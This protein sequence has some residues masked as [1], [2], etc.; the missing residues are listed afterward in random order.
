MFEITGDDVARL[1]D[2]D[3]RSLVGLLCA[4]EA[5]RL[6]FPASFITWGGHQD[7]ADGGLDV[8]VALPAVA[9]IDG[10]V[11]RSATGFQVKS[12]AMPRH[13]ILE[14]MRPNGTLRPAI[15]DL[16]DR[17]GA[18]VIV[19]SEDSTS[20]APLRNRQAAM[21]EGVRDLPNSDALF[22]DFYDRG[23]LATWVRDHPGLIPWVREKIG[24]PLKGWRS[25]GPWAYDPEGVRSEYLIDE[26][27]RLR[28]DTE[29]SDAGLKPLEGIDCI[30]DRLRDPRRIVR[31]VGLSG[32]GKTRLV[33]A[34]FDDRIGKSSLDPSLAFYTDMSEE[35]DPLPGGLASE[36]ISA[37]T[38][39]ILVIDNCSPD[40]HRRLSELCRLPESRVSVITVEYDI[41]EDQPE[42]T[43]VFKLEP[44]SNDLIEKIIKHRFRELSPVDVRTV[45][46]F[47]GGNARI[48]IALAATVGNKETIAG[49]TD[50]ELFRRLFQQRHNED[51][52]LLLAA[53][54]CSLVYSFQGDDVSEDGQAEL[55]RIGALVGKG[56]QEM[57]RSVAE[58]QSRE[59]IQRR[60]IW[61]A[62]LPHAIANRLAAMA[63]RNIPADALEAQLING[64]PERLLK[65]L[66]RRLGYLDASREA[67]MIVQGWLG[68]GGLLANVADLNE[69]GTAMFHL[70]APVAPE[71][72]LSAL[73]TALL[74]SNDADVV[75]RCKHYVAVLRSLA[76][77]EALFERCITLILKIAEAEDDDKDENE[78]GKVFASLFPICY[79]G[80]HATIKQRLSIIRTLLL[81]DKLKKRN[82]GLLALKAVLEASRFGPGYNFE[83]GARSR[84]YGYW[85]RTRD[86]IRQWYQQSL[87]LA[88]DV[89]CSEGPSAS[90]V[91][92]V[93]AEKLRGLWTLAAV[94]DDLEHVCRAISRRGFWRDG[95]L[96]V[97]QTA[98]YDSKGF[99]PQTV[100]RLATLEQLLW[101]GTLADKIRSIVLPEDVIF[102]GL[103]ST[104]DGSN[105]ITKTMGPV[106]AMAHD[107]GKASA[108]DQ[109]SFAEL[110]PEL[111]AGRS[112]QLWN[113]ASALSQAAEDPAAVWGQM[114]NCL[115]TMPTNTG[116]P[117]FFRGFLNGLNAENPSL[118]ST[119]LDDSL[120]NEAIAPWYPALQT[121]VGIDKQGVHRLM[122]S[123]ELGKSWI[124][125]YRYLMAGGVT[126]QIDG[127]DFSSLLLRIADDPEG[128][129]I[130]IEILWMRIS[131]AERRSSATEIIDLGCELMRRLRFTRSRNDVANYRLGM[132]GRICLVGDKG[133]TTVREIC[134]NLKAAISNSET[135]GFSQGELLQVLLSAQPLAVLQALCGEDDAALEFGISILDQAG[136]LRRIPFDAIP[137]AEL[138]SWCDQMPESQYPAAAMGVIASRPSGESGQ[139]Q[140][141]DIA[142]KLLERAPDRI[143]VLEKF[144]RNF[145]PTAWS[146]SYAAIVESNVKLLD[147]LEADSDPVFAQFVAA[148]KL[149]LAKAIESQKLAE[150]KIEKVMYRERD[151]RFE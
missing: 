36:L 59:L 6:G 56:A 90:Q 85:P 16:A 134:R 143:A 21:R 102:V 113:F 32:V 57:F 121:A 7:A 49:L 101:P 41:R 45:A 120:E 25:Y 118:V 100:A 98:Y 31:L 105:D 54:A 66:S 73:E 94:Y 35:P 138:L 70:V 97:R 117:H 79:S 78:P 10:F 93:I 96:A 91:R 83:F 19:S 111:I 8:R 99:P 129:Y 84:D 139:P 58:L 18:Y 148:E 65:S 26:K 43:E 127:P 48:A 50:E 64:A 137:E 71:A 55:S 81:S 74:T 151:Q 88:E 22:L 82:L 125:V 11:P 34:L 3:L 135:S 116:N 60:G 51:G 62:V 53:Q 28:T 24:K 130:A 145:A 5:K 52:S 14:E 23:R 106:E 20:D 136:E 124:G 141:T 13:K 87:N 95:W 132:L 122:R 115:A 108:R 150:N 37:S 68:A 146:G 2:E 107:L 69:L 47:S 76:Y 119:L 109:N 104:D 89:A 114:V 149:R 39:A 86:D 128:L 92:S 44:S 38:R 147:E 63:L 110:L 12:A 1:T 123:L 40:L 126:H 15:R 17:S 75:R 33:Q 142:R 61:R 140:W 67:G 131:F 144:I 27:L 46:E 72:T 29:I 112:Q 77:D 133:A 103:N 9:K 30:R 80:T 42:G 4:G